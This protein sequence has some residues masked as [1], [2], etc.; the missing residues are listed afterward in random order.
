[1][2][3]IS[4][5]L[6]LFLSLVFVTTANATST[7]DYAS[8]FGTPQIVDYLNFVAE[9]QAD[10]SVKTT[11]NAYT[12]NDLKYYKVSRSQTNTSPVYPDD[13]YIFYSSTERAYTDPEPP[14]GKNYY[15]VCAITNSNTRICS[16]VITVTVE[17]VKEICIQV[18]TYAQKGEECK[19]YPTPCDVP[20]GWTKVSSCASEPYGE[21]MLMVENK[22]GKPYLQWYFEEEG[23]APYGYKIA[24]STQNENPT[25]PVMDGDN[26]QYLPQESAKTYH[27]KTAQGAKT[28]HYRVCLYNNGKCLNYSNA[29]SIAVPKTETTSTKTETSTQTETKTSFSDVKSGVW[30]ESYLSDFVNRG[31]IEGY[32]DGTFQPN[33]T[34]NRAEMSKMVVKAL[35]KNVESND[36]EIFCD[37]EKNDWYQPYVIQLYF[38]SVIEGYVGGSCDGGKLFKASQD[39]TRAEAI[40]IILTMFGASV[41]PLNSGDQ[42][43]FT[44]VAPSHWAAAYIRTAFS[45]GIVNGYDDGTFQPD[46]KLTRAEFVKMLAEAEKTL[47]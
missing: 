34:V 47:K 28:Y 26:Y 16:N 41:E 45:L 27:H 10:G 13:G 6:G 44:D 24:I 14:F 29:V 32:S 15:R 4:S 19:A 43:G 39:V 5:L 20:D 35:G 17:E 18:I 22:E 33:R 7:T 30:F 37:V 8:T 36:L 1:M 40:K 25:Y 3:K 23:A 31:I 12:G 46:A 38:D 11:W 9:P 42:T 2:S 21:L